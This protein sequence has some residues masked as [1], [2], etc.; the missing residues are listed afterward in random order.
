MSL[1]WINSYIVL[2]SYVNIWK[3]RKG[4]K[5]VNCFVWKVSFNRIKDCVVIIW[6]YMMYFLVLYKDICIVRKYFKN[7][8]KI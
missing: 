3:C 1:I 5:E 4:I 7:L 8:L 6:F 2:S